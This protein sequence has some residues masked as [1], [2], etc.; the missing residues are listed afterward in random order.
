MKK[1]YLHSPNVFMEWCLSKHW[2]DL[3]FILNVQALSYKAFMDHA[4]SF[5]YNS[6][7]LFTHEASALI[8]ECDLVFAWRDRG[9][10]K[11]N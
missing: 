1:L 4:G 8:L 5:G 9:K 6:L 10:I 7:K 3:T 2:D 11:N